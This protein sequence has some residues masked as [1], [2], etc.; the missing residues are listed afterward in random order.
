VYAARIT[1]RGRCVL[2]FLAQYGRRI[3]FEENRNAE[4]EK[5]VLMSVRP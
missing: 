5:V 1:I 2:P 4:F 3:A